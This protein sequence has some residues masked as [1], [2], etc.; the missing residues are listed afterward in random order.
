MASRMR[1]DG[2]RNDFGAR[3]A[4]RPN[5]AMQPKKKHRILPLDNR[6]KLETDAFSATRKK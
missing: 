3:R 2:R 6:S 4:F 1:L 5:A